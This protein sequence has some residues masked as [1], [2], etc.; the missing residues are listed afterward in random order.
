[1]VACGASA[2]TNTEAQTE[3]G[4]RDPPIQDSNA[5]TGGGTEM[6]R[7]RKRAKR[8]TKAKRADVYALYQEADAKRPRPKT[9]SG[10]SA[11]AGPVVQTA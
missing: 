5:P 4:H 11:V 3:G 10:S 9:A 2:L 1:M 6:G 7:K 8:P